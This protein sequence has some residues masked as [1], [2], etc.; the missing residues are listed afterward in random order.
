MGC[1]GISI[2][3]LKYSVDDIAHV[4]AKLLNMSVQS[5]KFPSH[6]KTAY[7]TLVYQKGKKVDVKNY[8]PISILPCLS[9][10]FE[11]VL[12]EQLRIYVES[13]CLLS[14]LQHGFRKDHSC[15]SALISL[16]NTLF[17]NL[18]EGLVT[19]VA[20]FDFSKALDALDHDV[21]LSSLHHIGMSNNTNEWFRTYLSDRLRH[22][23]YADELSDALPISHGVPEG[24]CIS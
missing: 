2:D 21:L 3:M 5:N 9:K 16:S 24:S 7:I 22:V 17:A 6:W 11:R 15:Q 14:N 18:S 10:V 20:T 8:R 13:N 23:R 12:D 4:I 19:A 1:D